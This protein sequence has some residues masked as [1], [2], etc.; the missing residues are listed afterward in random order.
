M[1]KPGAGAI[2]TGKAIRAKES[3]EGYRNTT[4]S[5]GDPAGASWIRDFNSM[6]ISVISLVVDKD[7]RL[8][9]LDHL[10]KIRPDTNPGVI[11]SS[12]CVNLRS[13]LLQY[14]VRC[15]L[16][17]RGAPQDDMVDALLYLLGGLRFRLKLK[18]FNSPGSISIIESDDVK[19]KSVAKYSP[20]VENHLRLG[21]TLVKEGKVDFRQLLP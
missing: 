5:Y 1:G 21:K 13:Q 3:R 20:E 9:V 19:G 6:G 15:R 10:L 18:D 14:D 8:A 7:T 2:V 12:K 11:I 17:Q 16:K 4:A